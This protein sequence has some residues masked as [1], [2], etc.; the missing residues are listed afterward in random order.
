MYCT[1]ADLQMAIPAQ[2]L[3]WLTNDDSLATEINIPVVDE[4]ILQ[5][6]EQV[7]AYLRGRYNLPLEPVPTVIKSIVVNLAR[8]WLYSRRPEGHDFPEA[9]TRTYKDGVRVL[10][11]IRDNKITL[12]VK[13][14]GT[15]IREPGE[16]KIRTRSKRLTKM[17]ELYR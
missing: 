4:A 15:A 5:A 1:L 2:T 10:E 9:V 3:I 8:H 12:G 14:D 11:N 17:L 7:D 16:M 13:E 6:N